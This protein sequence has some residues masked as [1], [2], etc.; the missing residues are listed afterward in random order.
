[1]D[2]RAKDYLTNNIIR[3]HIDLK[4]FMKFAKIAYRKDNSGKLP[5]IIGP[6]VKRH[7]QTFNFYDNFPQ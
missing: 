4:N 1:M 6:Y 7:D 3:E 5:K 2:T